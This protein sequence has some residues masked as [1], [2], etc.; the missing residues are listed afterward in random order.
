MPRWFWRSR[1]EGFRTNSQPF[2][3]KP[4]RKRR[5]TCF[6]NLN[7]ARQWDRQTDRQEWERDFKND[8]FQIR[9]GFYMHT[10]S[11]R[12]CWQI[13]YTGVEGQTRHTQMIDGSV[14]MLK[15][16]EQ[17]HVSAA[18]PRPSTQHLFKGQVLQ[19]TL[20]VQLLPLSYQSWDWEVKKEGK[21]PLCCKNH[22]VRDIGAKWCVWALDDSPKL[23][24]LNKTATNKHLICQ[25]FFNSLIDHFVYK[26]FFKLLQSK[27]QRYAIYNY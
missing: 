12:L 19:N 5:C 6:F 7:L 22:D 27:S 15:S 11:G 24:C 3:E 17:E 8:S 2:S 16:T 18:R 25:C 20:T 1:K 13:K 21:S 14:W 23:A 10:L 26:V 9:T 4:E